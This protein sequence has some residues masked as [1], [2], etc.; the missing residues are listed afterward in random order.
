MTPSLRQLFADDTSPTSGA[1]L[2]PT[3]VPGARLCILTDFPTD[4]D[5]LYKTHLSGFAGNLLMSV[6]QRHG[7]GRADISILSVLPSP[8]AYGKVEAT[9]QA[10]RTEAATRLASE[11][12]FARPNLILGLGPLALDTLAGEH[13][14]LDSW[15]GSFFM[16]QYGVKSLCTW[17]PAEVLRVYSYIPYFRF[18][19]KKA[20]LGSTLADLTTLSR[21]FNIA[22]TLQDILSGFDTL[23]QERRPIALDIEGGTSNLR[24]ISFSN[25]PLRAFILPFTKGPD[26]YWSLEEE[27]LIWPELSALLSDPTLPK[28]LQNALYDCFVLPY[29]YGLHVSGVIDDTMLKHWELLPEMEKSLA[30]QTSIYTDQPWYKGG[31]DEPDG[32]GLWHYCCMDSAITLEICEKQS[33]QL[34]PP[35]A[36][37]YAFNVRLLAPLN[38]IQCRGFRF[39]EAGRDARRV[40]LQEEIYTLQDSL[41]EEL[42]MLGYLP[43]FTM[44]GQDGILSLAHSIC[45]FK[46]SVVLMPEHLLTCPK[47]PYTI[48]IHR[49]ADLVGRWS[50][51]S[52][53]ERGELSIALEAGINVDSNKQMSMLL[54]SSMS[55]PIQY[56]K[57]KGRKTDKVTADALALLNLY[58]ITKNAIVRKLLMLRNLIDAH[59]GLGFSTSSDGRIRCSLNL[60]GT[61]TG[62]V[63]CYESNAP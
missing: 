50:S 34:D 38:Y 14:S 30:V 12:S 35:S 2:P 16:S 60:V 20:V 9:P 17:H 6:L 15:R 48:S 52:P 36:A 8:A 58:K 40:S 33:L 10:A 23:R 49:I 7:L 55:L 61:E 41:N 63:A 31:R 25:H 22:P 4:N 26:S 1:V 13:R 57:E 11:I 56:K 24:C 5:I 44:L 29:S 27:L 39:D 47:K 42:E 19:I 59:Q 37:H 43:S 32:P 62:R 53:S 46:R 28:V 21:D 3:L 54:Y 51:L 45:C 18:D